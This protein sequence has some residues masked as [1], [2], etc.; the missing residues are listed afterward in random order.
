MFQ[1]PDND[2][3]NFRNNF[4][5]SNLLQLVQISKQDN[6]SIADQDDTGAS[7]SS[8]SAYGPKECGAC[9]IEGF[10]VN[11]C[12]ECSLWLCAQCSKAHKKVPLT[13]EHNLTSNSDVDKQC[14]DLVDQGERK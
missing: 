3:E 6:E 13:A 5:I 11:F 8:T 1:V 9:E 12:S 7:E 4:M 2:V 10:L 14:K